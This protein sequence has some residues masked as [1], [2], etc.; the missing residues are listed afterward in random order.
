ML[1]DVRTT[2]QLHSFHLLQGN[3]RNPSCQTSTVH[4]PRISRYTSWIQKS[5]RNQ[6]SHCQHQLDHRKS[7]GSFKKSSS[8]SFCFIDCAKTFD[9]VDHNKL[10]KILKEMGI[11]DHLTCLLRNLHM[12]QEATFRAGLVPNWERSTS[13]LCIVTLLVQ[14]ICRVHYMKCQTE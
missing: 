1:K 6:K 2:I 11:P 13:R 8:A 14:L 4:E 7:N 3:T 5:Q 9:C 12:H 10:W